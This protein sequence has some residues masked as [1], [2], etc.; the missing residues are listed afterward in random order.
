MSGNPYSEPVST[1]TVPQSG[2][3]LLWGCGGI[4]GLIGIGILLLFLL[5]PFSRGRGARG[6]SRRL[7][8]KNNLKH[9]A[10]ALHNYPDVHDAFPPAFT[11]DENGNRLHSWRTLILP[12][13]EQ[14]A[15]YKQIDLAKP[16]DDPANQSAYETNILTYRCP[17]ADVAPFHATYLG[18][19]GPDLFFNS[20][21]SRQIRDIK[22]GTSNTLM[23]V[24]VAQH[25]SVHWMSPEDVD[26]G[27]F[28]NIAEQTDFS[29]THGFQAALADGSVR[30][31]S[32]DIAAETLDA[33][34][35]VAGGEVI[36]EY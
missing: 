18:L 15:L 23:V 14:Q 24:E 33:L 28:T 4:V 6:A 10:L 5:L 36:G 27:F 35:T 25:Q 7:Q 3:L 1:D 8:C 34:T 19:V 2:K 20:S 32:K 31:L 12:Y 13:I 9:I 17:A 29:H 22:D 30:Y 26:E 16:W 21:E 11:V